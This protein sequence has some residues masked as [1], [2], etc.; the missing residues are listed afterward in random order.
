MQRHSRYVPVGCLLP[1]V[2]GR[3]YTERY[4]PCRNVMR[5]A[6]TTSLAP[7]R[8]VPNPRLVREDWPSSTNALNPGCQEIDKK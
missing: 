4:T 5:H 3:V 1:D 2:D 7:I 8:L 6:D